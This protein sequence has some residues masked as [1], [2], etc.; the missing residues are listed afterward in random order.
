M[1]DA[2]PDIGMGADHLEGG[3]HGLG[4]VLADAAEERIGVAGGDHDR[5]EDRRAGDALVGLDEREALALPLVPEELRVPVAGAWT[6][7]AP[8]W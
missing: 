5:A 7:R 1:P 6:R 8:R 2:I 3:A 4:V